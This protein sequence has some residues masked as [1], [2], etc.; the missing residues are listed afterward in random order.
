MRK[1]KIVFVSESLKAGGAQRIVAF[2][3]KN[4]NST[5][6][7]VKLV[8]IGFKD[9]TVFDI[10]G[11]AVEYLNKSRLLKALPEIFKIFKSEKPNIVFS[12]IGHINVILGI[13]SIF[14]KKIKFVAR[15]ASVISTMINYSSVN[16]SF[17]T[18]LIRKSYKKFSKIICQSEDMSNDFIDNFKIRKEQL[19]VINNPIT[20]IINF[21][22]RKEI[23]DKV[24]FV[25]VG[26]LSEEKGH[27]RLLK[28][29][30]K[31][32][33]FDFTYTIIGKGP[34]LNDIQNKVKQLGLEEKV[35]FI[36]H[37]SDIL[38]ELLK[39]D[40]FLQGSFVE[41]FPNALLESCSVSTPVIAFKA[42]GGTKE[43]VVEGVNGYLVKNQREFEETI[44]DLDKL[45]AI[46]K[47]VKIRNSVVEKFDSKRI[48][49]TY[50]ATF[51]AVLE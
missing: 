4:M 39:Y 11:V 18:F 25:T 48:L 17:F 32:V 45:K 44:Q 50:E 13:S 40:Y 43:I 22:Q 16:S 10:D 3:A 23:N 30:A 26:R 8:V 27:E 2:L 36:D 28:G 31:I 1:K 46:S 47:D 20:K 42:P 35:D 33:A 49:N 7:D 34:L 5:L 15:E 19:V 51:N 37:R 14:F 24:N 29:L 21:K 38:N 12:S 9:Q 41:G 6:F